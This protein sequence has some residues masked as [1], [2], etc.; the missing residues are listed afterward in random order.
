MT[1]TATEQDAATTPAGTA[2]TN[3]T[4]AP[5]V[6][7]WRPFRIVVARVQ[8]LSPAF[9]RITFTG[10]DLDQFG[11]DGPDQR[12]KLYIPRAGQDLPEFSGPDWYLQYRAMDPAVRGSVRTYTIRAVRPEQRELDVD[13]VL[14]GHGDL[15]PTGPAAIWAATASVGDELAAIGPN[16]LHD[17]DCRGHE[18]NPPPAARD[19]L[20]AGDETAVPA[21]GGI[22]DTL[23]HAQ[24]AARVRVFLEVPAPADVLDLPAPEHTEITW[25][26][27]QLPDG[28]AVPHGQ[29]LVEAVSAATFDAPASTLDHSSLV[30]TV[31]I[32]LEV[33]WEVAAGTS[34]T[35]YAWVAGEAGAV[36]AIRR[37]LV[38]ERGIDKRAVTF[39]GY[40]RLGRSLD[41]G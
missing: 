3:T 5:Q 15:G 22:L 9:L 23:T 30:D 21:I 29:R 38:R 1:I 17:G 14:H 28:T 19:I 31:D 7:P 10:E 26:P 12:I 13:F 39:M 37:H 24:T 27:R 36:K 41:D 18:W 32:D 35:V 4:P 40:W 8:Q 6:S 11:H 16:R 2:G 33:L 34:S 25:L 20:I